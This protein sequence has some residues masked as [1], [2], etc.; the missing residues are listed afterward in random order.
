MRLGSIPF[1]LGHTTMS[2]YLVWLVS[3]YPSPSL[4]LEIAGKNPV[5]TFLNDSPDVDRFQLIEQ[6]FISGSQQISG[7]LVHRFK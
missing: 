5:P 2:N 7:H 6:I 4:Q 3:S 1:A